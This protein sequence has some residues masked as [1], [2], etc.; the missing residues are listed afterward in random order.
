MAEEMSRRPYIRE[1]PKVRWFFDHPS[2]LRYMAREL[3]CLFIGAYTLLL[4]VGIGRLAAL[5]IPHPHRLVER[6]RDD[7][8]AVDLAHLP[9]LEG[10]DHAVAL[11]HAADPAVGLDAHDQVSSTVMVGAAAATR[12]ATERRAVVRRAISR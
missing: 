6:R 11:G 7:A 2:Y 8:P 3:T 4:V 12:C 9:G 10:F 1:V 5:R